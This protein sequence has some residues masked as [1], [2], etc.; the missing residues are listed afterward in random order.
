M[1]SNPIFAANG[2]RLVG[3]IAVVGAVLAW[4]NVGCYVVATGGDFALVFQ[5]AQFLALPASAQRYFTTAMTL[6]VLSFYL[7]FLAIGGYLWAQLRVDHG[8]PVDIGAMCI[9]TYVVMGTA[10]AAIQIAALPAL[11]AQHAGGDALAR[12][13]SETAWQT[14]AIVA[15]RGVWVM[16]GP[17]MAYWALL[18]GATMHRAGMPYGRLL[19]A[20][21]VC[22]ASAF[23]GTVLGFPQVLELAQA[24]FIILLPLW[25]LL[26]G[27]ALLRQPT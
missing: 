22:Y 19:M 26:T 23:V 8:A 20:N 18:M 10:G 15:Q 17:V 13:A 1:N 3:W 16:E 7:P 9:V 6:D 4:I 5:P 11:A 2:R 27:V 14:L 21:G 25:M 12:A 24:I